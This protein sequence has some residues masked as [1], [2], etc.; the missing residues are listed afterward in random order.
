MFASLQVLWLPLVLHF[1]TTFICGSVVRVGGL[2]LYI[3]GIIAAGF[4]HTLYNLYF[5]LGVFG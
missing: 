4:V 1:V 5:V 3:M 2:R